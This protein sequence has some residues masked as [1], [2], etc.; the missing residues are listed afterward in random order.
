MESHGTPLS[1]ADLAEMPGGTDAARF[2]YSFSAEIA[3]S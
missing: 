1:T 2:F 3:I